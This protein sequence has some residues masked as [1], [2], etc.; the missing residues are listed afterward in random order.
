MHG[1][2][3]YIY[4][5]IALFFVIQLYKSIYIIRL[6]ISQV[7][8]KSTDLTFR[9]SYTTDIYVCQAVYFSQHLVNLSTYI[10]II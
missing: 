5:Y 6:P 10:Y 8:F 1:Q 9:F 7:N 3:T 2:C 4:L